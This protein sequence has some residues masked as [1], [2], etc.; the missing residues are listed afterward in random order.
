MPEPPPPIPEPS[1]PPDRRP[2][3][4]RRLTRSR[5]GAVGLAIVA[6]ALL[7][8]PFAGW[9]WIPWLAGLGTLLLLRLLR[10]DGLLRGWDVH[11]AGLAV[12]VGL[13]LSTG[14]W[15]W[16]FGAS[17]GVLLAGF[18]QLPWW[19]LAAVG[20]VLCV[21]SGVG[22]WLSTLEDA[23]VQRQIQARAGDSL[24]VQM[25]E[26]RPARVF[27]T[28]LRSV[29]LDDPDPI[30][31]LLTDPAEEELLRAVPAPDC[32]A[33][34]TELHRRSSSMAEFNEDSLPEPLTT[35]D[36]KWFVDGC[37][38]MWASAAGR[39]VGRV[40]VGQTNPSVQRFAVIG[41]AHC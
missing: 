41:F 36:G 27:P 24:R 10:L 33:A 28:M 14:P 12:V 13:M 4:W 40:A 20:A 37:D 11:V 31:R 23:E 21:L 34:V 29:E 26:A 39:E 19:R 17:I 5:R 35:V 9:S 7:L 18:A 8:W 22:F 3:S 6:A 30:C 38:T 16:A 2:F 15:A 32:S 25:G 1:P